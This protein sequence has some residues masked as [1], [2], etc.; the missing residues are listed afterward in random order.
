MLP[1]PPGEPELNGRSE[2]RLLNQYLEGGKMFAKVLCHV[3][4]ADA[5]D[6]SITLLLV[7]RKRDVHL[8]KLESI[9][10]AWSIG[11]HDPVAI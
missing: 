4:V 10:L 9:L 11:R 7:G 1:E 3:L 8:I 6:L 2:D 5:S